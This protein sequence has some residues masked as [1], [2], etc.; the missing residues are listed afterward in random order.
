[1]DG[2]TTGY[3]NVV[4]ATEITGT[5]AN[6]KAVTDAYSL[7]NVD[8]K[9]NIAT[10]VKLTASDTASTAATVLSAADAT[11]TG[12]V[13]AALVT[14]ITGTF[15]EIKAVTD[16]N[17]GTKL[18]LKTGVNFTASD[19]ASTLATDLALCDATTTGTFSAALV[20]TITGTVDQIKAVTD[21]SGVTLKSDVKLD[22]SADN[23]ATLAATK[24]SSLDS[25]TAGIVDASGIVELTG[26][27][28]E[29]KAV[30]DNSGSGA[31]NV[32]LLSTV[33]LVASDTASTAATVLSGLDGK[34]GGLVSANLVTELT[35]TLAQIKA[36]TDVKGTSVNNIDLNAGVNL[37]AS[38]TAS[39][40]ATD[41]SAIQI[42][43]TGLVKVLNVTQITGT[44]TAVKAV[45]DLEGTVAGKID[46]GSAVAINVSADTGSAVATNLSAFD[47]L[48]TGLV[49]ASGI[50]E[51]TGT[52]AQIK[53]VT[54][55]AG[56]SQLSLNSAVNLTVGTD[57]T[58]PLLASTLNTWNKLTTGTIDISD[59]G[60]TGTLQGTALEIKTVNAATTSS[61]NGIK[62]SATSNVAITGDVSLTDLASIDSA[63]ATV[64]YNAAIYGGDSDANS[65]SGTKLLT[66]AAGT[67]VNIAANDFT[68]LTGGTLSLQ[69]DTTG[70][71][72]ITV[73]ALDTIKFV[74]DLNTSVTTVDSSIDNGVAD[75]MVAFVRGTYSSGSTSFIYAAGGSDALAIADV[76]SSSGQL[77]EAIVLVGG[78][79]HFT[80]A[81]NASGQFT[82]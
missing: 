11:T 47:S 70:L 42:A 44:V 33:N 46:L 72:A 75:N 64:T 53:A 60:I 25:K 51:L 76:D 48:T 66:K 8:N 65:T 82:F 28:A 52:I 40:V 73:A 14:T 79:N 50:T 54:D 37:T 30:T 4:A 55:Y 27:L 43:T 67:L 59:S 56:T 49:N 71:V 22:A 19:T 69:I 78:G 23:S 21:S 5:L 62:F 58:T 9:I 17:D 57:A 24:L 31:T 20:T 1:M 7:T 34:T 18:L 2:K 36:V 32:N 35:G 38:D 81:A 45:T 68:T 10:D 63:F 39:Q 29:I 12:L 61:G 41:L 16:N 80:A 6:L 77:Y 74:N 3:I 26:T 15:T 13:S